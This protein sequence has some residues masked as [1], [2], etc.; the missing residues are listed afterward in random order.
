MDLA[1]SLRE[2]TQF[3]WE[4]HP[5]RDAACLF[6]GDALTDGPRII[7][8]YCA[9]VFSSAPGAWHAD[10]LRYNPESLRGVTCVAIRIPGT[11]TWLKLLEFVDLLVERLGGV[12]PLYM[13]AQT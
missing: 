3:P 6:F 9:V 11:M 2:E 7:A 1:A 4:R 13:P 8:K 10:V 12:S 5:E